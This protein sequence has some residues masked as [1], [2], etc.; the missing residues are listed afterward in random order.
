[1]ARGYAVR[2]DGGGLTGI[3]YPRG[4]GRLLGRR[5]EAAGI[6]T[7]FDEI[8]CDRLRR[9]GEPMPAARSAVSLEQALIGGLMALGL[10]SSIMHQFG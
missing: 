5:V 10:I 6:R 7:G 4:A 2:G 8:V 9:Y 1:M 3:G